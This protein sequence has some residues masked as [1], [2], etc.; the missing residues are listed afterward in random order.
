MSAPHALCASRLGWNASAKWRLLHTPNRPSAEEPYRSLGAPKNRGGMPFP[1][2]VAVIAALVAVGHVGLPPASGSDLHWVDAAARDC[3]LGRTAIVT[4]ATRG[5]GR[6]V[7]H[8]LA[9]VAGAQT[10]LAC[11]DVS[12]CQRTAR[13]I[14]QR[15]PGASVECAELDLARLT[16][17]EAFA[18]HFAPRH[19]GAAPRPVDLI[20]HNAGVMAV[21]DERTEDGFETT[22][23]VNHLAPFFLQQLLTPSLS[24]ASSRRSLT[25]LSCSGTATPRWGNDVRVVW[26]SSGLHQLGSIPGRP[27]VGP[28][29]S[30]ETEEDSGRVTGIFGIAFR[31]RR[32]LLGRWRA[33]ADSKLLN[34]I[35]ASEGAR[36]LA[37]CGAGGEGLS[38]TPIR[39]VAVRPGTVATDITRHSRGAGALIGLLKEMGLARPLDRAARGILHACTAPLLPDDSSPPAAAAPVTTEVGYSIY[40]DDTRATPAHASAL[41]ADTTSLVWRDSEK[42]LREWRHRVSAFGAP[43]DS[44]SANDVGVLW[45]YDL[46]QAWEGGVFVP[47]SSREEIDTIQ[48]AMENEGSS[49]PRA[50]KPNR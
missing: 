47:R 50:N 38:A 1:R 18:A 34:T 10:I 22:F 23:Q 4:G 43:T 39:S 6:E 5:I 14:Q 35:T 32:G 48:D 45:G 19:K 36:R 21:A 15:S 20:V 17:V 8:M 11:R 31:Q 16:S 24:A 30:Q 28:R 44:G 42:L 9:G 27:G 12:A 41:D 13:E 2:V 3:L 29:G 40:W 26:V 33:Y 37:A 49:G 25:S 7:A 46:S